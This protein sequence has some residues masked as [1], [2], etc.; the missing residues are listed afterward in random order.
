MDYEKLKGG[1]EVYGFCGKIG[2]GKN[3]IA[4]Q[5][6]EKMMPKSNSV[7]IAF[8]DQLKIDG[9]VKLD[10]D[11]YKCF[12]EKDEHTRKALQ[13]IGTEEG[14][15]VY[16]QDLWVNY[17]REW[18]L[19]HA[20]RGVK[21]FIISDVRFKNE[22]DLIE[23]EFNGTNIRV[24]APK[25]NKEKLLQESEGDEVKLKSLSSHISETDLDEGRVFGFTI[26]NDPE[27]NAVIQVR[28]IIK[29]I[30]SKKEHDLVV[31]CDVDD[32]ICECSL[33]YQEV[34]GKVREMVWQN[35]ISDIDKDFF[36]YSF[37]KTFKEKD[38]DFSQVFFDLKRSSRSLI[39]VVEEFKPHIDHHFYSEIHN[40]AFEFGMSVFD[41]NYKEIPNRIK[42]LR[43]I[44]KNY[45]VVLFTMGD[46]LEQS[47]KICQ[48]GIQDLDFEIFD[49]KDATIFR[50][51]MKK[52]P[53]KKYAMIGDSLQ[54]DVLTAKEAGVDFPIL[55]TSRTNPFLTQENS[56]KEGYYVVNSILQAEEL[57]K[58]NLVDKSYSKN[59]NVS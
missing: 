22:F 4:E 8:A 54:R 50:N 47:K 26:L 28:E 34:I 13:R 7:T 35:L 58:T 14:R 16:G 48:L 12:V 49:F 38:G 30:K 46:Y 10:L 25:R 43:D 56:E 27:D 21:R 40:K 9:I 36:D 24:N 15:D 57:L 17:I 29:E 44:Q 59:S 42:E 52:Y 20:E 37:N 45:K 51:L 3:Y 19:T 39:G 23:N 18:V 5:I 31:F 33:Y 11:R 1:I 41:F 32:T 2:T 6:F 55:I 53:S